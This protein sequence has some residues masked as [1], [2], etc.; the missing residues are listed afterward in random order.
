MGGLLPL[1]RCG[2]P[3]PIAAAISATPRAQAVPWN[4]GR[5]SS[6]ASNSPPNGPTSTVASKTW[7]LEIA[8]EASSPWNSRLPR[9]FAGRPT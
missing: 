5:T 6:T 9:A 3:S 4:G 2:R 1:A 8:S 7:K